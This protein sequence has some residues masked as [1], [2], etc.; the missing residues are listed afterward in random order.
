M[1][2]K[3]RKGNPLGITI[4]Q[5]FHSAHSIAKFYNSKN[6]VEV[7]DKISND[8]LLRDKRARIFC[9]KRN[10]DERAEHGFMARIEKQFHEQID[11]IKPESTRNHE[12]ISEYYILWSLRHSFHLNR[13]SNVKFNGIPGSELTKEQQENLEKNFYSF[14]TPDAEIPARQ[15]TSIHI[16]TSIMHFLNQNKNLKWGLLQS[17]HA[18][19]LCADSYHDLLFIPISPKLAFSANVRDCFINDKDVAIINRNSIDSAK[20]FYFAKSLKKCPIA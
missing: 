14:V 19:L 20:E 1:Y 5:H 7:K 15:L 4:E 13:L 9:T 17:Q 16:Q 6:L 12:A 18:H 10:W 2:E 3:T 11:I 8:V